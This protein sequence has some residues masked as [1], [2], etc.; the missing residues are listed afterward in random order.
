M[1]TL[2][3][4][5]AAPERDAAPDAQA[6]AGAWRACGLREGL[7]ALDARGRLCYY[8]VGMG[9]ADFLPDGAFRL[10]MAGGAGT[11]VREG[12]W[13]VEGGLLRVRVGGDCGVFRFSSRGGRLTLT[14]ERAFYRRAARLLHRPEM[15]R[16][17]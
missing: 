3:G 14:P 11:F 17:R 12:H 15:E 7:D 6:L 1:R 4:V 5:S 2:E 13:R 9:G 10:T 16:E 8:P